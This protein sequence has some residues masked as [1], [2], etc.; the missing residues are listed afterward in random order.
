MWW[1]PVSYQCRAFLL[2]LKINLLF[3]SIQVGASLFASNI[4]SE[5]FIGLSGTGAASG[6]SVGAFEFNAMF[7]LQ[8]LGFVFL[9]VY[10]A[11]RVSTLP[12]YMMKRFG[13]QRIRMYLAGLSMILY[14]FTK[15]SVNLYSGA[16]FIQQALQ[17]NLYGS[18]F[19]LLAF[20]SICTIGGGLTAVIYIDVVQVLIMI[21]GS[22]VLLIKG[23]QEVGG[24]EQFQ[25]K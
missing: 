25:V 7:L 24:W 8:L 12:E 15:I 5:H 3:C 23:L 2:H 20:T 14:I 18:I 1:L 11:S 10:I 22:S 9:P 17:W 21:A 6:I 13:G 19:A 16:L 4:G